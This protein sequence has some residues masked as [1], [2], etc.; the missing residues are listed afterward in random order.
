TASRPPATST[1]TRPAGRSASA[2]AT[3]ATAQ[4]PDPQDSVSPEPRSY[5]RV[6]TCRS[7]P[8]TATPGAENSTLTPDGKAA[9]LNS[10]GPDRSSAASSCMSVTRHTRCGL[11][12]STASPTYRWPSTQAVLCP[13]T[14]GVDRR[15]EISSGVTP[16]WTMPARVATV[17]SPLVASPVSTRYRAY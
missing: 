17:S 11:P 7:A 6:R 13:Y 3:A 9:S 8:G 15:T 10:G 14:L 1:A 16:A 2:S 4:A 12:T 5:T